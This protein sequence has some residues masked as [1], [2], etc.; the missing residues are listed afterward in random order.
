MSLDGRK[1]VRAYLS[2]RSSTEWLGK[3][4]HRKSFFDF[5]QFRETYRDKVQ[6]SI[7]F[8][9]KS[10]E[11]FMKV[12]VDYLLEAVRGHLG[13]R[14]RKKVLDVG[15]GVGLTDELLV[16]SFGEVHGVDISQE[17]IDQ[18]KKDHPA[19]RYKV[20]DGRRLPYADGRFDV[21]FAIC[22]LRHV[23]PDFYNGFVKEMFRVTRPG[24]LVAI[25][26]HN[27]VNPLTLRAVNHCPMDD[28]AILLRR[29]KVGRLMERRASRLLE[30]R[31]ILF[32]PFEG[33]FFRWLDRRLGWLP[34]GAQYMITA[35]K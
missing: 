6:D 16:G 17:V 13:N 10:H 31:Y 35:I 24:G 29:W 1:K 4:A 8:A 22:V 2:R 19:I 21:T 26:E 33:P 14:S 9:G 18:A 25:F 5:G 28:E 7:A 20:Y 32:A 3:R 11:F 12:K 30:K 15:C 34:L 27:P 23:P